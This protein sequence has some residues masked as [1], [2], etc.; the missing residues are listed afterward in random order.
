M[1]NGP[2]PVLREVLTRMMNGVYEDFLDKVSKG[3]RMDRDRAA[4]LAR[5]RVWTGRQ[6]AENGLI[7]ELGGLRD[8]IA[9][10]CVMGGGLDPATTPLAEYPEAPNFMDQLKESFEGMA[11]V[12]G[13]AKLLLDQLAAVPQLGSAVSAVRQVLEHGSAINTTSVQALMPFTLN[14][15]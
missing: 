13:R 11:S 1:K 15:R 2:T 10:A 9:L 7:D 4:E 8:S 6:A 3:R 12:E 5:G 14:V